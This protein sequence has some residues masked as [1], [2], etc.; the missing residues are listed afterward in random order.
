MDKEQEK[1]NQKILKVVEENMPKQAG[2]LLQKRLNLLSE[3][4]E[5]NK[6]LSQNLEDSRGREIFA[7]NKIGD[8][9]DL[10][11]EQNAKITNLL[12]R[13]RTV[14]KR[15][16]KVQ[17]RELTLELNLTQK[18]LEYNKQSLLDIKELTAAVFKNN[19]VR[20]TIHTNRVENMS[21]DFN[22]ATGRSDFTPSGGGSDTTIR[23]VEG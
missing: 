8:F 5:E 23:D 21:V 12:E 1:M 16:E 14:A 6:E 4:E 7:T 2:E 11:K 22:S 20:E 17:S 19:T 9:E 15:E 13:E 10:I 18:E 3:L